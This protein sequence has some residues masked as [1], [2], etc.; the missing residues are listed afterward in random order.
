LKLAGRRLRPL[1]QAS[2]QAWAAQS[3]LAGQNLELLPILKAFATD[4]MEAQR[5]RDGA[6]RLADAQLRQVRWQGLIF[7]LV[8]I[9]GAGTVL[10]LLGL[11]Q[12]DLLAGRL[13]IGSLVSVF[14]YGVVLINPVGQLANV[15]GQIQTARGAAQRLLEVMQTAPEPDTG[16][17]DALPLD[18]DIVF[19]RVTFAYPGRDPVL[20]GF[21]LRIR[22]GETLAIT[23]SNGVG[24]STLAHLL[25]RLYEP[26]QGAISIGGIELPQFRLATL[27]RQIGLVPQQVLLFHASV[28]ANI[29]Y[30]RADADD[31]AIERAARAARAHDFIQALP[32]GYDTIIGD[33]GVKLSGGQ[34]QRLALARALLRDPA[35]LILD[36][37][38]AMFDPAGEAEFIHACRDVLQSRTVLLITHRPASL[39]LADR[40]IRL[41][42]G[43][44]EKIPSADA[45][46]SGKL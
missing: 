46:G 30:G 1:G 35:I 29:A 40:V 20:S 12:A 38:T 26:D 3:A 10:L 11:A 4:V 14:L 22:A 15:Y 8:Q 23:G 31:A 13:Q 21:S 32:N 6:Y 34:R 45:D 24:K 19:D 9:A 18:G 36:E 43:G 39:A 44:W 28:R 25:L 27:R 17:I 41:G 42:G 33:Q 16:T 2:A 7:P 37:A 5:Y